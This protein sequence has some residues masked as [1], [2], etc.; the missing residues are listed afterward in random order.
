MR[1][2]PQK[3]RAYRT[4][5]AVASATGLCLVGVAPASMAQPLL[6][7]SNTVQMRA[8][9]TTPGQSQA[10]AP[11]RPRPYLVLGDSISAG[12]QP[13]RGDDRTGGYARGVARGLRAAGTPVRITNL[14]CTGETTTT[15]RQGGRCRYQRGSQRAAALAFLRANPD[16]AF[17]SVSL[18]ANDTLA[19]VDRRRRT[20]D[21]RCTQRA[22]RT[23]RT[24]L[25]STLTELRRVAPRARIVVLDYYDPFQAGYL[26]GERALGD[27]AG[28]MRTQVNVTV[29][30]AARDAGVRVAYV[31]APFDD[32]WVR[33]VDLPG[34]GKV[35]VR[36]ARICTWTWMCSRSDIHP[37]DEGYRVI[38][39][40]VLSSLTRRR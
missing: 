31:S 30:G 20:V 26:R 38:A 2:L 36:V 1:C 7:P 19:C 3:F 34:H 9:T 23:M 33:R 17:I 8:A 29:R 4:A 24:N 14:A 5:V 21:S 27:L 12:Y 35:P 39:G 28:L 32:G 22:A 16:T 40:A 6:G 25:T 37:N 11:V 18:G 13:G 10:A 15:M